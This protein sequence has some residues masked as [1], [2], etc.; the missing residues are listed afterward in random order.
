MSNIQIKKELNIKDKNS[1]WTRIKLFLFLID[2][3]PQDNNK[4]IY[5]L[6]G[7][8]HHKVKIEAPRKK[9]YDPQCKNCQGFGHR[10][11]IYRIFNTG[12]YLKIK[13]KQSFHLQK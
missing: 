1:G 10:M 4:E 3:H 2:L 7:L 12:Y 6:D 8:C 5:N 13:S 11:P 9:K